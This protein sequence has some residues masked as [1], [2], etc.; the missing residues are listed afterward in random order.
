MTPPQMMFFV[1]FLV[2]HTLLC[3]AA[4]STAFATCLT[5]LLTKGSIAASAASWTSEGKRAKSR[6]VYMLVQK[7]TYHN[8]SEVSRLRGSWQ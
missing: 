4:R 8:P 6:M 3:T 1:L 5:I 7:Q 2:M